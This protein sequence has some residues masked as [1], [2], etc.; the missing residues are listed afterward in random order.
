MAH[1]GAFLGFWRSCSWSPHGEALVAEVPASAKPKASLQAVM[2]HVAS[3]S[4]YQQA[5]AT[6]FPGVSTRDDNSHESEAS[7][8]KQPYKE[9]EDPF[10]KFRSTLCRIWGGGA[11]CWML[12]LD[13]FAGTTYMKS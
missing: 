4:H 3:C 1:L 8:E 5:F 10:V 7:I 9:D 11:C 2:Q 13:L 12:L 6:R